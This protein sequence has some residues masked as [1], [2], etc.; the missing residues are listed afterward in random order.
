M[1]AKFE[2]NEITE[3]E[4]ENFILPLNASFGFDVVTLIE[5]LQDRRTNT[6]YI[7][8][9]GHSNVRSAK[10]QQQFLI[11]CMATHFDDDLKPFV[12]EIIRQLSSSS[13]SYHRMC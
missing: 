11:T 7:P 8:S 9:V 6:I 10:N 13:I 1:K 12:D 4:F 2:D 5:F 3:E